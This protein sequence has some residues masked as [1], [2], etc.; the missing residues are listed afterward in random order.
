MDSG[1]IVEQKVSQILFLA[2][3]DSKYVNVSLLHSLYTVLGFDFTVPRTKKFA[4]TGHRWFFDLVDTMQDNKPV[5]L[6]SP[7]MW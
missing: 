2:N 7:F 3:V 4:L 1:T 6:T 5:I